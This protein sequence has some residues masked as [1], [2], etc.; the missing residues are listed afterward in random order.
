M[1]HKISR[2]A[3]LRQCACLAAAAGLTAC[4]ADDTSAQSL[5]RV[6]VG[7]IT[8]PP[9]VYLDNDGTPTG[10]DVDIAQEAFRRMGCRAEFIGI[11]W[12][13]KNAL[14]SGGAVDCVWCCFSMSGRE[15]GYTWAGP[16]MVSTQ[17]V[18]VGAESDIHT[19]SDLAGKTVMLRS[20]S[21]PEEI[22][23]SGT[24]PRL[25]QVGDVI[26]I[27]DRSVQYAMLDCGYV[28]AV[29][30]HEA[31]I[32]QYVK[33]YGADLRVLDEPL[34]TTGLGVAFA[35]DDVRGLAQRL[36]EVFVQMREDGTLEAIIGRYLD[37]APSYLE[38]DGLEQ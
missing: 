28:D 18:A 27:E 4:G 24:D 10:I 12:D 20:G 30:A 34:L 9:Y 2:R 25:P 19:F 35:A 1:K 37:N 21:R 26:S 17:V 32:S 14:L 7:S 36:D 38:V 6:A 23:L 33:D 16:Y 3:F 15:G 22:F 11:D 5:P 8:Y 29:A 31:A 13:N